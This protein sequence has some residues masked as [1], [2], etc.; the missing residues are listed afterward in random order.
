MAI[1][2]QSAAF[3]IRAPIGSQIAWTMSMYQADG[4]S[5]FVI[6]GHTFEYIVSTAPFGASPPGTTVIKL[7]S[8]VP[9]SPTPAGGGSILVVS[10]A[11]QS[12]I[13]FALYPP[14]TTPLSPS[15][16]YHAMWMDY[17]DPVN[18]LNLFW[19]QLML[20]PAVQP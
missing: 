4:I 9:S 12:A 7:R 6:A 20:D 19:G 11:V 14:A 3:D 8:D 5:P 16:Y 2:N 18:A 10:T 17:A 1:G 15:T 13:Q